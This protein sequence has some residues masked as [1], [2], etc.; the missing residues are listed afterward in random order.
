[1]GERGQERSAKYA[2]DKPVGTGPFSFV[3]WD[4]GSV[5]TVIRNDSWWGGTKPAAQKVTWTKFGSDDVV[6]QALR[7]GDIDIVPEVPPTIYTGLQ[8][9]ADVKTTA[10]ES[11]SF[12]MIGFNCST[13][14]GSKGNPPILKDQVV[15]QALACAVN[16]QQLVE[17]ALAGYGE[18]GT[19]L[20]PPAFGDFF[21][22]VPPAPDAVLD[23]NPAKAKE[24]LDK[25]GYTDRNGDG[26]RESK[27]GAPLDFRLL[28]IAD[29]TVD[30]KPPIC[31]SRPPR[32][33]V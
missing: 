32:P 12:H 27:D 16:R 1:M 29:T 5:A 14:P 25:A 30:M 10:M 20:L 18:P 3:S 2:N 31:S 23:N 13:A 17:L 24:L 21:H 7:T 11:F 4:K 26:I 19:D 8:N 6:T 28:V 9:A 15:R 22:F 33:S